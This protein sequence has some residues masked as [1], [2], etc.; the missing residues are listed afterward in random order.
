MGKR[1]YIKHEM[2]RE[3]EVTRFRLDNKGA[4]PAHQGDPVV[5]KKG[6]VIGVVTSCSIDR[7][8]SNPVRCICN[9]D[10]SKDGT[11]V[12]VFAGSARAKNGK[13]PGEW[14]SV[15]NSQHQNPQP[16]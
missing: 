12:G 13:A 1:A 14:P 2:E 5:D 15:I 10:Y 11:A 9:D 6:K 3:A 7:E 4:R 16:F 8:G